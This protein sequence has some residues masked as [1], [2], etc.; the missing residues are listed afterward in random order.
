MS[1]RR[2]PAPVIVEERENEEYQNENEEGQQALA[3][4]NEENA[5]EAAAYAAPSRPYKNLFVPPTGVVA[6]AA[7][8]QIEAQESRNADIDA[9]QEGYELHYLYSIKL[10]NSGIQPAIVYNNITDKCISRDVIKYIDEELG[11]KEANEDGISLPSTVN[12]TNTISCMVDSYKIHNDLDSNVEDTYTYSSDRSGR[13]GNIPIYFVVL[14]TNTPTQLGGHASI[15]IYYGGK[16][17]SVGLGVQ[18][19]QILVNIRAALGKPAAPS[20]RAISEFF[21]AAVLWSP[22]NNI[23]LEDVVSYKIIDIGFLKRKHINRIQ[24]YLN[25][26]I[27]KVDIE[28]TSLPNNKIGFDNLTINL[29]KLYSLVGSP[30]ITAATGTAINCVIFAAD[31]F[32]ERLMCQN[33]IGVV[34]DPLA[35]CTSLV[36]SDTMIGL[37]KMIMKYNANSQPMSQALFNVL[38]DDPRTFAQSAWN[39]TFGKCFARRRG[40]VSKKKRFHKKRQTRH[41]SPRRI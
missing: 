31:I 9:I 4:R 13:I 6:R 7:P 27:K 40:G 24:E 5:N 28:L 32:K 18:R 10:P 19:A 1:R 26:A 8:T 25:R 35:D 23:N 38:N 3:E 11:F 34:T 21:S 36:I 29:N 39:C 22:D 41:R 14:T 2:Q 37:F 12:F 16:L 33:I 30:L 20:A 15:I 17:F